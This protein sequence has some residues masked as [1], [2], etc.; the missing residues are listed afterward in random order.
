MASIQKNTP[1]Q[2]P[3]DFIRIQD[4]IYLCLGKWHWFVLSLTL[5]L[6][7]AVYYLLTTPP[8]YTRTASI[9]IKDD[10]KGKTTSGEMEAFSDFGMFA[11]NTNVNNEMG[12]LQSPDLMREVVARLHLEMD[13]HVA[14]R[15]HKQTIY[16]KQLPVNVFIT[17]LP[18]SESATFLLA[19]SK[20]GA[21]SM[22][23]FERNGESVGDD[24]KVK[25]TLNDTIVSPIG[26]IVVIPSSFYTDTTERLIY[27]SRLPLRSAE[28]HY[29]SNLVISQ[30]DEKSNII[31]LSFKDVSTQR[32][33]DVLNTLISIYNENWVKDKNQIAVSTSMFINERLGIIEGEL[34]NV[35]DDISS[36]K[37]EHLLPDVQAAASM[38]MAQVSEANA[39]IKTLNN[40]AYM[41]RYIRGYLTNESN[42]FQLLPAN[43]GIDNPSIATQISAYNS[44][45]LE[46]NSLVSHSSVKNPLVV[47]MDASLAAMR[48]ALITSIDNQLV[49]LNAQIKTQ[50]G[51]SGQVT[52]QIASNPKQAKYLLSVERQQKVKESLYLY[53]LQKREENELS[54]AFTAYNT[55]IITMPGGSMIPTTPVK[56]N[57]LLVA[58]ALGFLIPVIIIFIREN[59]NTVVRGRQDLEGLTIPF[60]GEIPL[61]YRKRGKWQSRKAKDE[62]CV[63]VVKEKNRNVINEAFRVVRTN[64]EFVIGKEKESHVIMLTSANP[65]SGKTFITFNLATSLAIKGK[66]VL[67]IDLDLRKGSLSEYVGRPKTGISDYLTGNVETVREVILK[68]SENA[69]LDIIP[70]GTIPPNPTEL[71]FVERLEFLLREL[72]QEYDYIFIDCPPVEIVAD[73]AIINKLADMTLFI[74]RAGLMDRGMLP[75]VEK[76]Y[77][78]KKYRNLSVI[79]NGTDGGNGR[80]GY[81]Y[82]YKYGYKYGYAGYTK[83]E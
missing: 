47:E 15:F 8:V 78:E 51:Y 13:Y 3:Q 83:E 25:G 7:I 64:L 2:N 16:G 27:V 60:V 49:A 43:S 18:E 61:A 38:Y 76:F 74:I 71:L 56:K 4:L 53:L 69:K 21:L 6:G 77:T 41:A 37:S 46:R 67:A 80:Y 22:S 39:S 29:S 48:S 14:G 55:R 45:L 9:L 65:G 1:A 59:T 58:L 42:K 82:G 68:P 33:E 32:A 40:Q 66:R 62:K 50:Q 23:D 52:S 34:G 44:Q 31:T 73:A 24:I 75:E 70:V 17:D 72:R 35:D 30:T 11:T 12:T 36:Y 79:L 5:C 19:L 10:S 63:I 20:E 57:I 81:R 28:A 26:K 54:Q